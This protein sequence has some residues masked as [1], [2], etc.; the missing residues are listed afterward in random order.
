MQGSEFINL[1]PPTFRK[2]RVVKN[3]YVDIDSVAVQPG[4]DYC[5]WIK[6]AQQQL[7]ERE[8]ALFEI[9]RSQIEHIVN[10]ELDSHQHQLQSNESKIVIIPPTI[11]NDTLHA[12]YC[13]ID[14]WTGVN[15]SRRKSPI[16]RYRDYFVVGKNW[17]SQI[18]TKIFG[19]LFWIHLFKHIRKTLKNQWL[20]LNVI[21]ALFNGHITYNNT[22]TMPLINGG[23]VVNSQQLHQHLQELHQ[24]LQVKQWIR[25][26][27][28]RGNYKKKAQTVGKQIQSELNRIIQ[29]MLAPAVPH[30]HLSS[31]GSF[32]TVATPQ[33]N[34]RPM[35][36][37]M[38]SNVLVI[39][40][41]LLTGGNNTNNTLN[42]MHSIDINHMNR[43]VLI[44]GP[45]WRVSGQRY[46]P[47]HSSGQET[48]VP[49]QT[50]PNMNMNMMSTNIAPQ[51]NHLSTP[52]Q[53]N[54]VT[55]P[56]L[57]T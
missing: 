33:L 10:S 13:K 54:S 32:R 28:R 9:K 27:E 35:Q 52:Q 23:T 22:K 57:I 47:M 44:H 48:L 50:Y 51:M 37:P 3:A 17:I 16:T 30:H 40:W 42:P 18:K 21:A 19:D 14:E 6:I 31:T 56:S 41:D 49:F 24:S 39:P 34:H 45:S 43:N 53:N 15:L 11:F 55:T 8:N 29:D 20:E 2:Q 46:S 25:E 1:P 7:K 12:L 38:P 26:Q 5:D 36:M 4:I